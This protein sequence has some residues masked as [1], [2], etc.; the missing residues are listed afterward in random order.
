MSNLSDSD[1][2][3]DSTEEDPPPISHIV[4]VDEMLHVGVTLLYS[5]QRAKRA[6]VTTNIERFLE[7]F[8]VTPQSACNVYEDLQTKWS[9]GFV[10]AP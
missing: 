5:E 2:E 9:D 6:K 7:S 10:Y 8:G 1:N 3:E 4:T